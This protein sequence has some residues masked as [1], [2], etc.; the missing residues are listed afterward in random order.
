MRHIAWRKL[1]IVELG[2]LVSVGT[3]GERTRLHGSALHR[4]TEWSPIEK[5]NNA[6]HSASLRRLWS[7]TEDR[8]CRLVKAV[9]RLGL[10]A[11]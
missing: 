6:I 9:V 1:G 10:F 7:P 3:G 2:A 4:G 11:S 8:L 5:R